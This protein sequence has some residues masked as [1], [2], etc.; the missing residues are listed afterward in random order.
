MLLL[1]A[2]RNLLQHTRRTLMLGGA[3]AAVTAVLTLLGGL[4]TGARE[5]LLSA[6][7]VLST[8]HVNVTGFYK[9]RSD[10]S[11]VLMKDSPKIVEVIK[12]AV[13][14][15]THI[16]PRGRGFSKLINRSSSMLLNLI[17]VDLQAEPNFGKE[18][19]I[20]EGSVAGLAEPNTAMLFEDQAERLK[21]HVGD[22]ITIL[23]P[24]FRGTLNTVDARVVAIAAN[25]GLVTSMNYAV[26][27]ATERKLHV[28]SD[29]TVSALQ[30]YLPDPELVPSVQARVRTALTQAGY[31]V[32]PDDPEAYWK[33]L[34]NIA[35][36]S[37]TGERLDVSTWQEELS[38]VTW[39]LS[40]LKLASGTLIAVM[41]LVVAVGIMNTFWIAI[42]ERTREIGT[43]RAIGMG[44]ARVLLMFLAEGAILGLLSACAGIAVGVAVGLALN[45]LGI[46]VPSGAETVLMSRH[47]FFQ[48]APDSL[49]NAVVLIAVTTAAISLIPSA[50]A[51]RLKPIAAMSSR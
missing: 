46:P 25:M 23:A 3:I 24:T 19:R 39:T 17:G 14:E 18:L 16:A 1:I 13:P 2:F 35:R 49:L 38:E 31:Q 8:G 10:T 40:I 6:A 41:M 33:K 50:V 21:V 30:I 5:A 27:T 11:F 51:S 36:E 12:R 29:D 32:L 15:A 44:R 47:L 22:T 42:R 7:T 45:P 48:F 26:S 43:L 28:L 34:D 4:S 37:W 9:V 20:K